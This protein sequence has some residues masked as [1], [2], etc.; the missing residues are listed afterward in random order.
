MTGP[1]HLIEIPCGADAHGWLLDG[2]GELG[3]AVARTQQETE[4]AIWLFKLDQD[5]VF[6]VESL[7]RLS[8]D[9]GAQ[10]SFSLRPE[11]RLDEAARVFLDDFTHHVL[12]QDSTRSPAQQ[13]E[14]RALLRQT[15]TEKEPAASSQIGMYATILYHGCRALIRSAFW[16]RHPSREQPRQIDCPLLIGAYGG[17][18]VG[19]AA[20]LGGVL[21]E[22]HAH[23]GTRRA[24]LGS[25][26]PVHSQRLVRSLEVPVDVQVFDYEPG[27]A[28][29]R[30]RVAD[31]LIFAGGPLMDLPNLLVK[32][33]NMALEARHLGIPFIID[34]IGVGPFVRWPSRLVARSI[35]R[36]STSLSVRTSGAS[37]QPELRG[38]AAQV[39]SDPAF[40]YLDS[41]GPGPNALTQLQ[42]RD[43]ET[44]DSLLRGAEGKFKVGIN[45]RPIRHLWSPEGEPAS[46]QAETQCLERVAE[47]LAV[48]AKKIPTRFIFFPMNPIQLG[49]SDLLSA[50]QLHKL[51]GRRADF[52]VW[53]GDPEIDGLLYLLRGLDA[54]VA[55]RFHACIFA[56][57]QGIPTLGIDYYAHAGGKVEDLFS[58]R[59][60]PGNAARIDTLD[61]HWLAHKLEAIARAAGYPVDN[62]SGCWKIGDT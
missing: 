11:A 26:R 62:G 59:A 16:K 30:L 44:V 19:D 47:A 40:A 27:L 33:W 55:M 48:T 52:Q 36:L 60:S 18:H 38:M 3:E 9:L 58:D 22:L 54:V 2:G 7:Y 61:T 8:L 29:E 41:R 12:L 4:G 51:V 34:R 45:L 21:L 28:K 35:A 57:S 15:P 20:I 24:L 31:A 14:D 42:T 32:H 10:V 17:E 50:W 46:R 1:R 23:F 25:L 56:L 39:R 43:R 53:Q 49:G 37:R 6:R 13:L 5:N